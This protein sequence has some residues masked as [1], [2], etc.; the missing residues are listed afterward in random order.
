[1]KFIDYI[2]PNV[3]KED[4]EKCML[5]SNNYKEGNSGRKG[6]IEGQINRLYDIVSH[7]IT[8][9]IDIKGPALDVAS[10]AGVL[11]PAI[12]EF[13]PNLEPYSIAELNPT[14]TYTFTENDIEVRKFLKK[15][16]INGSLK[17]IIAFVEGEKFSNYINIE[18]QKIPC[19]RFECEREPMNVEDQKFN[20][21]LFFDILEHLVIDPIFTILELN[22]V[23]KIGGH[24][25]IA[26]PNIGG[27]RNFYRIMA[28]VNPI[29]DG[30]IKPA[31]IY[32]SLSIQFLYDQGSGA[33]ITTFKNQKGLI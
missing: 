1:M 16:N 11:F 7:I 30:Q 31:A 9:N 10:S 21:V 13:I 17:E 18:Q 23:L 19:Y 6:Y 4:F 29:N 15:K 27:T 28:G 20:T 8:S 3:T 24:L 32:H 26:T 22:R 2:K 12:K 33:C 5:D 14:I 25:I